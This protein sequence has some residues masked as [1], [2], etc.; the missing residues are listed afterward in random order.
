MVA[1]ALG[2]ADEQDGVGIRSEHDGHRRE[3]PAGLVGPDGS[4]R[5]EPFE[6]ELQATQ[7]SGPQ[8]PPQHPPGG[9]DS[10]TGTEDATR[11]VTAGAGMESRRSTFVPSQEGQRTLVSLRTSSSNKVPQLWQE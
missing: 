6:Q 11:A 1:L 8:T 5:G 2:P 10:Q 7:W 9:G 3:R 4:A